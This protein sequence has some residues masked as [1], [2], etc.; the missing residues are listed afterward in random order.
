MNPNISGYQSVIRSTFTENGWEIASV[1][2][3][4]A[5]W[6]HELWELRSLWAPRGLPA[7]LTFLIDPQS[8]TERLRRG[9]Y[10]V[11]AVKASRGVPATWQDDELEF[12]LALSGNWQLRLP[13][14]I[15]HL[16]KWRDARCSA[17]GDERNARA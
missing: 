5:W 6:C 10:R 16:G 9:E 2:E 8:Q 4:D 11:W 1:A 12:T 15:S 17:A 7:F 3:L 13:E 14:L